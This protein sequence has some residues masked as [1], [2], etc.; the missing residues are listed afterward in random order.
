M[1]PI[2]IADNLKAQAMQAFED[3]LNNARTSTGDLKFNYN[4]T[5]SVAKVRPLIRMSPVAY[6]KMMELVKLSSSEIAWHGVVERYSK[7]EYLITD[8]I[9]YPQVVTSVTVESKP[10]EYCKWIMELEDDVI[11]NMRFQGHSHVNMAT[12]PSGRDTSNWE[13]YLQA[14]PTNGFYLFNIVNKSGSMHWTIYDLSE[15]VIFENADIDFEIDLDDSYCIKAWA[16]DNIEE[17]ISKPVSVALNS[18]ASLS[19]YPQTCL[20]GSRIGGY[21]NSDYYDNSRYTD[22]L[23]SYVDTHGVVKPIN[24]A[25]L[26]KEEKKESKENKKTSVSSKGKKEPRQKE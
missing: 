6:L 18:L 10:D 1:K 12:S 21:Y 9:C 3:Y 13:E 19:G 8:I 4:L 2:R 24:S 23:A 22:S 17:Y 15:N 20:T 26:T 5:T 7:E 25:K 16:E 11:N 14:L